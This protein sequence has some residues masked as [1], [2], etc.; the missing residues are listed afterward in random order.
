MNRPTPAPTAM[1]DKRA[2]EIIGILLRTGVTIAALIVF[3]GAI[4]YLIQHGTEK[5]HYHTFH[6]V[7]HNLRHVA[8]I[9]KASMALDP[10]AIIQLGLLLLIATPVARVAFSVFAFAEECDWIYV[11]ITLIVLAL[12]LY[13]LSATNL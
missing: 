6:G 4:P 8:G 1:T 7:P 10:A 9:V 12:L 11:V 13:S 5:P 2:E 3:A